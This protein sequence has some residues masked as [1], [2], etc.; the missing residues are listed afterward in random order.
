MDFFRKVFKRKNKPKPKPKPEPSLKDLNV[1]VIHR[2]TCGVCKYVLRDLTNLGLIDQ[3][4][5]VNIDIENWGI[6]RQDVPNFPTGSLAL[7]IIIS[8]KTKKF[9]LGYVNASELLTKLS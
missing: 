2:I 5:L 9:S 6:Y 8:Q 3:V 4:K 7:P 1:V